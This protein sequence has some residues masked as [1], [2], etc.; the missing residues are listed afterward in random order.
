MLALTLVV[1][2]TASTVFVVVKGKH[3]CTGPDCQV[4]ALMRQIVNKTFRLF[5][6]PLTISTFFA[7]LMFF[8]RIKS[9]QIPSI[10]S[11][12]TTLVQLKTILNT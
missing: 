2:L 12:K 8:L 10:I 1:L 6:L 5:A 3:C 11:K 4:C 7:S 9:I